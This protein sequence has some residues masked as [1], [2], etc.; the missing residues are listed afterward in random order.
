MTRAAIV[1]GLGTYL[2]EDIVTNDMLAEV[3]NTSD[4]WIRSR[5]GI[6]QRHVV[7]EHHTTGD[8]AVKA[9]SRA[10]SSASVSHVDAVVVAT[11]TPDC[12]C[13]ATAPTVAAKLG[14]AGVPAFDVSAACTGFVY[15]LAAVSSMITAGLVESA[16]FVGA[17]TFTQ[18]L[19]PSDLSTRAL[20]G[21][22]A[23][24]VVLRAGE[25]DEDGALLA[26][27]LGSDGNHV[28][29]LIVPAV[30]HAER[31]DRQAGGYL[32]MDGRAVFNQA[33]THMTQSV[34][35]VLD[36]VG[37]HIADLDHLV[38]HQANARILA[39]VA[40]QL[41]VEPSRLVTNIADVGNT[42]AASIPLALSHGMRQGLLQGGNKVVMTGFGAGLT[43]GSVALRWPKLTKATY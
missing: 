32:R 4:A 5:T 33:V 39:A 38:P 2:P 21:D 1:S 11:T 40:D 14:M 43:W 6:R 27:D 23:G 28:D 24:A 31:A 25:A 12:R 42:V 20:F 26:F 41:D 34:Q 35:R 3:L 16:L 37:W 10:L 15:G 8:L 29:L 22:G 17:D 19:D 7:A 36:A 9:A 13:P 18:T 30:S